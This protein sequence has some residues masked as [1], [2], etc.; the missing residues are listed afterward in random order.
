[1]ILKGS[2]IQER[3]GHG[4]LRHLPNCAICE[5]Q[6][7]YCTI[8]SMWLCSCKPLDTCEED[9]VARDALN[10]THDRWVEWFD[11]GF[12]YVRSGDV[13]DFYDFDSTGVKG[14]YDYEEETL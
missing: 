4:V 12:C 8:C 2:E 11:G 7:S 10:A 9:K 5:E 1:M 6:F 13:D 3:D 14:G